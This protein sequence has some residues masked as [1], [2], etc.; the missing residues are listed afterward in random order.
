MSEGLMNGSGLIV[1][2]AEA[3]LGVGDTGAPMS[4]PAG[5]GELERLLFLG[6]W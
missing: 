6:G 4:P 1:V 2:F 3:D 5:A